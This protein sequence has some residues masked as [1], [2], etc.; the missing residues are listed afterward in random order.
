[1]RAAGL[2]GHGA[3]RTHDLARP[4]ADDA[5]GQG[6]LARVGRPIDADLDVFFP[7]EAA[8]ELVEDRVDLFQNGNCQAIPSCRERA[9]K[10]SPPGSLLIRRPVC[11]TPASTGGRRALGLSTADL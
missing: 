8:E 2:V 9:S 11:I 1:P 6:G 7:K 4:V 10:P 3:D 5:V